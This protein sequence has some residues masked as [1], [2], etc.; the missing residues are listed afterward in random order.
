MK[1][2]SQSRSTITTGWLRRFAST[3][4]RLASTATILLVICVAAVIAASAQTYSTIYSFTGKA[5]IDPFWSPV[6]GIDGNLYGTTSEGGT[7]NNGTVFKIT[8]GGKLTTIYSFCPQNQ[9]SGGALPSGLIQATNGNFYGVATFI[10]Y[11]SIFE[12]TPAGKLTTVYNFCSQP[13]CADGEY[14]WGSL[15]QGMDG[16]FYGT[17]HEG[18]ANGAGTVYKVTPSGTLTT[19]YNF[20][21]QANCTDGKAPYAGVIQD[22]AGN[23]YGTTNDGGEYGNGPNCPEYIAGGCGVAY[24]LS[25]SGV[26]TTLYTFCSLANCADGNFP[27][28]PLTLGSDG[29]LYGT[30]SEGGAA[31]QGTAFSLTPNGTLT[32]LHSFCTDPNCEDGSNPYNL[33]QA[34]DGNFYGTTSSG[35]GVNGAGGAI[36]QITP[37]GAF[38]VLYSNSSYGIGPLIQDT[39]G[40][41]YGT[42]WNG[43]TKGDGSIF[44]FSMGLGPFVETQTSWGKVGAS[45]LILGTDLTGATEVTFN[46]TQAKFTVTSATEIKATVPAAATTGTVDVTTP[47]GTL[48][49]NAPFEVLPVGTFHIQNVNSGLYVGVS[50]ASKENGADLVQWD[51]DTSKDQEWTVS[52]VGNG[53]YQITNVNSKLLVGVSGASMDEGVSVVQ[54]QADGSLDQ[55]WQF[56]PS[57][58]DWLITDV[59]SGMQMAI[60]G[61]ATDEGAPVIQWPANGSSSQLFTLIPVQ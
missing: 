9:C 15:L 12:I 51:L 11:G 2:V 37:E 40:T 52:L 59:N 57:G 18:G 31:A 5:G 58:A 46:G 49:S 3:S 48:T 19:L 26:L 41:F 28:G 27:Q 10:G 20:C 4:A 1:F 55:E 47:N 7:T 14:P 50:G 6:Q 42:S 45:V 33:I 35:D 30:T 13:N 56:I 22:A 44:S 39:N 34:T 36:Y 16:N 61:N 54:W 23:L 29:N 17:T 53:V 21:S 38:S 8:P 24:K 25:P 43:G 60:Q 32:T